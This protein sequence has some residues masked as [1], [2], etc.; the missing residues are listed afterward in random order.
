MARTIL[1]TGITGFIAKRIAYDLLTQGEKVRGTLRKAS[2]GEEVKAALRDLGPEALERL[3][4]VEADLMADE[5]W[6]AAMTGVDAVIH[7]AS[8][9]PLSKPKNEAEVIQP[10]VEGTKRVLSAAQAAGVTRVIQTSSMEAVM[11][12]VTS[13]PI[14]EADWSNPRAPTCSAYTRSKIFAEEAAW[15][16]IEDHHEMQL[17]V[18]NPGLVCGTP[19]DRHTGSSVAVIERLMAGKDPM[20]PEFDIPVVDV[21]DVAACHVAALDRPESIG[22]RYICAASFMSFLEMAKVLKAEFPDRKI[23]TRKAPNWIVSILALFD[24]QI[25]LI[26]PMLGMTMRLSNEAATR[27]LGVE[28]VPAAEAVRRTGHFIAQK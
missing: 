2:R 1:V 4:F 23:P 7:T 20:A 17:T 3:S 18:I 12:G 6:D 9:F 15:E 5:G 11:H 16:F 13:D 8:P 22:R 28:F 27:D 24:E 26:K 19:M 14:T 25:A 10:A 21:A